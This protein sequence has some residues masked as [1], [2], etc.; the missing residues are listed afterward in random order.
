[1]LSHERFPRI[2][3]KYNQERG[4]I[5]IYIYILVKRQL[6]EKNEKIPSGLNNYD[7]SLRYLLSPVNSFLLINSHFFNESLHDFASSTQA[8][9]NM[10]A[11]LLGFVSIDVIFIW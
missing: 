11:T 5:Y 2:V 8:F 1:M 3:T 4:D 10:M 7:M 9:D 6:V